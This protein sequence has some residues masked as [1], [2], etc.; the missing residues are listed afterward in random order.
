L[1]SQQFLA[2]GPYREGLDLFAQALDFL[3]AAD[4]DWVLGKVLA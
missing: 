4:K 3:S 2:V 1:L